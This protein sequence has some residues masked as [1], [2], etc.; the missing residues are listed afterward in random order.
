M[1]ERMAGGVVAPRSAVVRQI[2]HPGTGELLDNGLVLWFQGP[3]SFTGEDVLEF[4]IHGGM[5]VTDGVLEALVE[6]DG[7]RPAEPG[8]FTRRAFEAGRLDLSGVEGLADLINAQTGAQR[9]LALRDA[10]GGL[11][12]ACETWRHVIMRS[13][14]MVEANID[15]S[16]ERDVPED[17]LSVELPKLEAVAGE[18]ERW[19]QESGGGEILRSGF[20]VVIAGIPNVGKSSLLNVIAGRKAAIVTEVAGTT[21]DVIEVFLDLGGYP[22]VVSDTAGLRSSDDVVEKI[23]ID[24]ALSTVRGAELVV[25]VC[26]ERGEWPKFVGEEFDSD[27]LWVRNKADLAG[28]AVRVND[29]E[30]LEVSAQT[31]AGIAGLIAKIESCAK[32]RMSGAESGGLARA[33]HVACVRESVSALSEA[34]RFAQGGEIEHEL[35]GECLRRA[36]QELGRLTGRVD[37]ED[38]LDVVFGE[39]CIGK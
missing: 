23:G 3:S 27:T 18:M 15:F 12:A 1:L 5:A 31:G 33:R 21:R 35:I 2:V 25:W 4:H 34:F 20:R 9:R 10:T 16:D 6:I 29:A 11:S 8:E 37:V 22:V 26:D 19:L 32:R 14:A 38:L 7:V 24:Q 39:F 28:S 30:L 36:L 13:L 17:L